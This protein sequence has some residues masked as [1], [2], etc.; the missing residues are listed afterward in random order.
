MSPIIH[1]STRKEG[2]KGDGKDEGRK[3]GAGRDG[4][5]LKLLDIKTNFYSREVRVVTKLHDSTRER[6]EKEGREG[7]M[8][9]RERGGFSET[10][11]H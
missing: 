11:G 5:F 6:G 1:D 7:E 10:V 8:R 4:D 3:G 9:G 2:E